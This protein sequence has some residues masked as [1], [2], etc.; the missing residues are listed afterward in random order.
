MALPY[1]SAVRY[2][3]AALPLGHL[4]HRCQALSVASPHSTAVRHCPAA[5]PWRS[6]RVAARHRP[7]AAA[8]L[9][10]SQAFRGPRFIPTSSLA[11]ARQARAHSAHAQLRQTSQP[12]LSY[13]N[14]A[15]CFKY[16]ELKLGGLVPTSGLCTRHAD[17]SACRALR[18]SFTSDAVASH[19]FNGQPLT[20]GLLWLTSVNSICAGGACCF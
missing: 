11:K 7:K 4:G 13:E 2:C 14:G 1:D 20:D 18:A 17:N 9:Q 5:L 3:P 16:H 6:W 10:L 19:K 12:I 8:L 15:V